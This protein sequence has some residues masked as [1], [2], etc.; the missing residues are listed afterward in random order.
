MSNR[1]EI[2]PPDKLAA[3]LV[4]FDAVCQ[5]K[6]NFQIDH[7]V[8]GQHDLPERQY[9]Q[10]VVQMQIAASNIRKAGIQRRRLDL[11]IAELRALHTVRSGLDLEDKL[12]DLENHEFAMR[13]AVREFNRYYEI[14]ESFPKFSYEQLQEAEQRYWTLRLGRQAQC[15]LEAHGRV[16]TG[17]HE[18]LWQ[19][20][21]VE[22]PGHIFLERNNKPAPELLTACSTAP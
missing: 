19:A 13:G 16:G 20:G 21:L 22:N 18:A 2:I 10:C 4:A 8:I 11:D 7:F 12:I 3:V 14:F 15:D 6:T 17:N 1:P 9:M 5:P